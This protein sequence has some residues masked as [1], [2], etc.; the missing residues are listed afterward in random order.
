MK[1]EKKQVRTS[2]TDKR[3]RQSLLAV[4]GATSVLKIKVLSKLVFE[5]EGLE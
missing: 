1:E 3:K 2:C 5:S 4:L